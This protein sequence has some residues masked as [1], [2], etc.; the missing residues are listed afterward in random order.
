MHCELLLHAQQSG[1]RNTPKPKTSIASVR[2]V[3]STRSVQGR[4]RY[5]ELVI[6]VVR[7]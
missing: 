1:A 7:C 3:F 4:M 5:S 6:F 2:V